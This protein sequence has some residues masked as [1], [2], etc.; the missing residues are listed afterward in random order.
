MNNL[1]DNI[2]MGSITLWALATAGF[3]VWVVLDEVFAL[4]AAIGGLF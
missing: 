1:F 2:M 3:C 4:L